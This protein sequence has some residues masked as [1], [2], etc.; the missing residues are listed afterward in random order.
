MVNEE[1]SRTTGLKVRI[2]GATALYD[3]LAMA[4]KERMG[5]RDWQKPTR[6]ILVL[7]R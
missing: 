6:R 1:Q 4:C 7:I 5:S 3:A 2:G